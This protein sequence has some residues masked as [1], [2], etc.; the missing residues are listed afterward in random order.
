M[1][2]LLIILFLLLP[3]ITFAETRQIILFG[4]E[5]IETSGNNFSMI[6]GSQGSSTT[7]ASF[8]N[9]HP[10]AGVFT[11][12]NVLL[13]AA[14]NNGAGSQSITFTL[15]VAGASSA[16]AC[17][18]TEAQTSCTDTDA[19]AVTAGQLI[20]WLQTA[21]NTPAAANIEASV[22]YI[23]TTANYSAVF[24]GNSTNLDTANNIY[25]SLSQG[26]FNTTENLVQVPI[27]TTATLRT[28]YVSLNGSPDNGAGT[29]SYVLTMWK[30]GSAP[31]SG[32]TCT[33]SETAT[34]CNDTT[35]TV[36]VVPG[37]TITI[38]TD[39]VGTP[40]TRRV[41]ASFVFDSTVEGE[42][43]I[44]GG[45][46][47]NMST[48]TTQYK[49]LAAAN[50]NW[51]VDE[52]IVDQISN[53][54]I[55]KAFY[56]DIDGDPDLGV[57]IQGYLLTVRDDAGNTGCICEIDSGATACNDTCSD[58]VILNSQMAVEQQP[59]VLPTAREAHWGVLGFNN[60]RRIVLI[61]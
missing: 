22:T 20:G 29:Q 53:Y 37:D 34:A 45:R 42:F 6:S 43:L 18:I 1:K 25:L 15:R 50:G 57:G 10:S 59:L 2:K 9:V 12:L 30:N 16:L 46:T 33:I 54:C 13:S 40:T 35:N 39:P 31:A 21:A 61:N 60:P 27:P 24:H 4:R 51:N 11:N 32:L 26:D 49:H 7:E 23:D 19:V 28:M 41:R 52:T 44:P 48:T 36:S 14:P 56:V 55:L 47:E 5:A 17:T 3:Q 58:E 38:E 8:Q